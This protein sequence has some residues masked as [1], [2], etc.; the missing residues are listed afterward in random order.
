MNTA[1]KLTMLRIL[2][3]PLFLV[4]LYLPFTGHMWVALAVFIAAS[5]TDFA[6]GYIARHFNQV[7]DFDKFMDPLADKILVMAAMI[8]FVACWRLPV[9]AL[10]IVVAREFAVTALR[11]IRK[12]EHIM[13]YGESIGAASCD[14]K[15]GDYVHVHNL[16]AL[17]G[18]GDLEGGSQA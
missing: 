2:L 3:I 14:I 13:K 12:G 5:V 17:R 16:E 11:D 7:P 1:N 10:V 8:W 18:R 15:K 4:V 9:W 6:D